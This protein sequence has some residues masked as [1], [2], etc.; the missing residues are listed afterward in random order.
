MRRTWLGRIQ[1]TAEK[2][3]FRR[4]I[5]FDRTTG[6]IRRDLV[7]NEANPGVTGRAKSLKEVIERGVDKV[8]KGKPKRQKRAVGGTAKPVEV[9]RPVAAAPDRAGKPEKAGTGRRGARPAKATQGSAASS[10]LPSD[11]GFAKGQNTGATSKET[12]AA[13]GQSSSDGSERQRCRRRG[14]R[15]Q[16]G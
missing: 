10:P 16:F 11:S 7:E 14:R 3:G 15:H 6:E 8:S 12:L 9:D 1:L 13:R 5:V 2:S 4:E